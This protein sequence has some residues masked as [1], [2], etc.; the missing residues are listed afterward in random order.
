MNS[1]SKCCIL[2]EHFCSAPYYNIEPI[3]INYI[4]KKHQIVSTAITKFMGWQ[5]RG[6]VIV[7]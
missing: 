1:L 6:K 5:K 3:Y 4:L 2:E 7:C